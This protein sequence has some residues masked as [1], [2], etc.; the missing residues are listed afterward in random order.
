M[1]MASRCP[2]CGASM[3]DAA[4]G[5]CTACLLAEGIEQPETSSTATPLLGRFGDY[6]L[7]DE[8]ARGGMGVVYKARQL[9]L[10][11]LVALKMI[12][13]GPL[14]SD[15]EMQRFRAEARAAAKLQHPHIVAIHDVGEWQGQLYFSM[16]YLAGG[17]L[18][19]LVSEGPVPARRA[20]E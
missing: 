7:I 20:T 9:R 13:S 12:L 10:G 15:L 11:R 14:A 19:A 4:L 17:D 3:S 18:A 2:R 8:I 1:S 6:E 16:D 5:F